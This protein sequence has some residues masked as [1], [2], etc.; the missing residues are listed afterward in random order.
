MET[1]I[2]VIEVDRTTVLVVDDEKEIADLVE[3]YLSNEGYRVLKLDAAQ[4]EKLL[5]E[6]KVHLIILDIMMPGKDGLTLCREL[7][8]DSDIP[9][10]MLSAR[11]QDID[12]IWGSRPAQTTTGETVQPSG[13]IAR[14]KALL[15][16]YST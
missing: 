8:R 7:R 6:H 9:V 16:R 2:G 4:A 1:R 13:L 14:V 3:I 11:S 5:A 10:L 15:R 12:K